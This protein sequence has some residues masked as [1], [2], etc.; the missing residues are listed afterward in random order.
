MFLVIGKD[1]SLAAAPAEIF[2]ELKTQ[3]ITVDILVNNAGFGDYGK[4]VETEWAKEK[5]MID[6]NVRSLTEMTKLFLTGMVQRKNGK[7][8]NVASTAAFQPGPLMSVYY[9]TKAYVLSFSEAIA[10]ELKGS[11]VTVLLF[12]P[13]QP[14]PDFNRQ[15]HWKNQ[16]W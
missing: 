7:I 5:M 2:N 3:N 1:L 12:V 14:N 9:A 8:M 16:N 15:L 4:F 13:D 11:G 10:E 6:L